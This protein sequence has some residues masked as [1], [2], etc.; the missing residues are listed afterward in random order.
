MPIPQSRLAALV[1]TA[2]TFAQ[3]LSDVESSLA[4]EAALL[5]PHAQAI[6]ATILAAHRPQAS[7]YELLASEEA[8]LR[9]TQRRNATRRARHTTNAPQHTTTQHTTTTH[10]PTA[11]YT[12][13]PLATDEAP[14]ID[15]AT[16]A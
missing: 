6:I 16:L 2:R 15:I 14:D 7:H 5:P 8:L 11:A 1:H 13:A 4:R 9:T 3:A 12:Y 10:A